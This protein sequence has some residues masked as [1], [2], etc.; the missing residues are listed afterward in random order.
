M[1]HA[2]R[3]AVLCFGIDLVRRL[4]TRSERLR[5]LADQELLLASELLEA[6]ASVK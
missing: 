3:K 5:S 4:E 1:R 6:T 2:I